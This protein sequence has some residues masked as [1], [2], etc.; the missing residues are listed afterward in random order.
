MVV[1]TGGGGGGG[2]VTTVTVL[3]VP[4]TPPTVALTAAA[5]VATAVARPVTAFT[6]STA[7]LVLRYSGVPV[8]TWPALSYA[9]A[10]NCSVPPTTIVHVVVSMLPETGVTAT[11][12]TGPSPGSE[13]NLDAP[14]VTSR[15]CVGMRSHALA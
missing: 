9:V 2:A 6:A 3:L 11:R 1:T 14:G 5:P 15:V 12:A 4:V 10:R 13:L 7:A 8:T